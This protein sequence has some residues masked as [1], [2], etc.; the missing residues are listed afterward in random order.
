MLA[1]AGSV[2]AGFGLGLTPGFGLDE[3]GVLGGEAAG[4]LGQ[5]AVSEDLAVSVGFGHD[6]VSDEYARSR[7]AAIEWLPQRRRL[8]AEARVRRETSIAMEVGV[9][10]EERESW[11]PGSRDGQCRFRAES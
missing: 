3:Y 7:E 8:G 4:V 2:G 6:A 11:G 5:E 1:K 9:V 10:E